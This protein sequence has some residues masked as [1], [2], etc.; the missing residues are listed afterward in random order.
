MTGFP[1]GMAERGGR[2]RRARRGRVAHLRP[3]GPRH[4]GLSLFLDEE[5]GYTTVAVAL[6]LLVSLSLT[7][8]LAQ[9]QWVGSR[10]A[11]V[12][13]V[14]DSCALS[15]EQV[16]KAYTLVA[17]VTDACVLTLGLA[18]LFVMG[19]GLIVCAVP[20]M[21]PTGLHVVDAGGKIMDARKDFATSAAQNLEKLE[22]SVPA[23]IA[24]DSFVTVQANNTG[25]VGY[26]GVAIPFPEEGKSDFDLADDVEIDDIEGAAEELGEA[27]DEAKEAKEALDRAQEKGWRADCVDDP[28]CM[29]SRAASLASLYGEDNPNY[30]NPEG[31]N[32]GVALSRA[33]AYYAA[34]R[35]QEAPAS[36]APDEQAN[37]AMRKVY[38][39]YALSEVN[40]GFYRQNADGSVSMELP[41]LAHNA[42][43]TRATSMYTQVAWP[44]TEEAGG[45]TIHAYASCPGAKGAP[46]GSITLAQMDAGAARECAVCHL[47]TSEMGRVAAAST[48]TTNG[49]EHYWR[50]VVEAS[51]EWTA[52][53]AELDAAEEAMRSSGEGGADAFEEALQALAVPR[54]S[55]CPPGAWGCIAIV[56]HGSADSPSSLASTLTGD[57]ELPAGCAMAAATLAPDD[58]TAE[59]NILSRFFDA[60]SEGEDGGIEGLLQGITTLWGRL[61]VGYGSA[62][63]G[64]SG[65]ARSL[66]DGLDSIGLG[67]IADWLSNTLTSIVDAL[68][69]QPADMRIKKPVLCN[70]QDV[71]D[72]DG[73]TQSADIRRYLQA[74]PTNGGVAE[75]LAAAGRELASDIRDVEFTVAEL[76]IPGTQ[77]RIPLKVSLAGLGLL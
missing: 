59:N 48:N 52:A 73:S 10:A 70:T 30:S 15:G 63:E 9:V 27:S 62:A 19:A 60:V 33:R 32:F 58:A 67:V 21:A 54:P 12:Q 11:D 29:R 57:A 2:A 13:A 22:G 34:R 14:A 1:C 41:S 61:L 68:G 45:R 55:L 3:H 28:L 65:A 26:A 31:W 16:V 39:A 77:I 36:S 4:L 76:P 18:G 51:H 7:L 6:A 24:A 66:F 49:F 46:A 74:M 69:F 23:L 38:Y 50:I 37:S 47:S 44:T 43:E 20:G 53:K 64:I 42:S 5:G 17:E 35:A 71:L 40:R 56:I 25:A 75:L 8:T 72:K